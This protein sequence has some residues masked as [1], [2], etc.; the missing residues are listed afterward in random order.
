MGQKIQKPAIDIDCSVDQITFNVKSRSAVIRV[1][2][3]EQNKNPIQDKV[4]IDDMLVFMDDLGYTTTQKNGI[5]KLFKQM[6]AHSFGI[7]ETELTEEV[8][9]PDPESET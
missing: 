8:F 5:K 7:A 1:N 2:K 9:P 6:I 4:V 3:K